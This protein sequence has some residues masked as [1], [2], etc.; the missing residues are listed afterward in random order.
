MVLRYL[1][2]ARA[3]YYYIIII[4]R[5]ALDGFT[6]GNA[7]SSIVSAEKYLIIKRTLFTFR[8]KFIITGNRK[9]YY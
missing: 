1:S 2:V 3:T 8:K 7:K 9:R 5:T 6:V 4:I